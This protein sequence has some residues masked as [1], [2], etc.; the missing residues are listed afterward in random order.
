LSLGKAR[1]AVDKDDGLVTAGSSSD[2]LKRE[3]LPSD[4]PELF[5]PGIEIA[6]D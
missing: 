5:P 3:S 2:P 6:G 1:E 4:S